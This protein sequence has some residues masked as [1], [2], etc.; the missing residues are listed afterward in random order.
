MSKTLDTIEWHKITLSKYK[1]KNRE[2]R[3][4]V[5]IFSTLTRK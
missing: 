2:M 1:D 5:L 4:S 3:D